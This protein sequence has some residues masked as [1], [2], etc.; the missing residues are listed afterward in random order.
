MECLS[1]GLN[2]P[3]QHFSQVVSQIE[4]S[5]FSLFIFENR[6]FHRQ[7]YTDIFFIP[8]NLALTTGIC[9]HLITYFV[10]NV[11]VNSNSYVAMSAANKV[12]LSLL[13]N[14]CLL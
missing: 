7:T 10:P 13:P 2:L 4:K 11:T 3:Y 8:A 14:G 6:V 12:A 1:Y 5:Q 9:V